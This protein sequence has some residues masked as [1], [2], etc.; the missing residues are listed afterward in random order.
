MVIKE[1]KIIWDSYAEEINLGLWVNAG[2]GLNYQSVYPIAI[3]PG[4]A[5]LNIGHSIIRTGIDQFEKQKLAI[6]CG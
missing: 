5:E 2:H 1:L 4:L 3:L 6:R